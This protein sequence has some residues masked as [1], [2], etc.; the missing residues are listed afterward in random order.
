MV[1]GGK[2]DKPD[3]AVESLSGRT[4]VID[5]KHSHYSEGDPFFDQMRGYIQSA[6]AAAGFL[7]HSSAEESSLW[8]P[9]TRGEQKIIRTR[10]SP[11][12]IRDADSEKNFE[13]LLQET[14]SILE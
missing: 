12:L 6:K 7:V 3:V 1:E 2:E 4:V 5:A 14:K 8:K 13:K 11:S 10:L 9:A